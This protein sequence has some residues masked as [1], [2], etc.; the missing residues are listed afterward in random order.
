M[1]TVAI[2]IVDR[3]YGGSEEGGWW[4]DCGEPSD[5][6]CKYTRGFETEAEAL[7]YSAELLPICHEL[8]GGRPDIGHS[9]SV[10]QYMPIISDGNPKPFPSERPYYS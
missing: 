4:Y 5:E 8:N 2:Y 10:G 3:A 1:I 6:Q 7:N 9:N